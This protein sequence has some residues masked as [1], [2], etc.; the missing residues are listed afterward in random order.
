VSLADIAVV[1][2]LAISA[3]FAF[4]RGLV[5]EVLSVA[6][7]VGAGVATYFG[8]PL[9]RPFTRQYI[10]LAIVAD[11]V[12]GLAI[13]LVVLVICSIISHLL[14]RGVRA[15]ALGALDRS[16]GL[17]F[18]LARGAL[19]VCVL[20]LLIDWWFPADQRPV[21]VTEAK[22]LPAVAKGA[23][24]LKSLERFFPEEFGN[25]GSEV[26][27]SARKQVEQ[28]VELGKATGVLDGVGT[29]P[30]A[31]GPATP[32]PEQSGTESA[33]PPGDSGYKDADRKDLDKVFQS[34]GTQ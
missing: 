25:R 8:L 2:I 33:G 10:E 23:D 27:D 18:G 5:R 28:A 32:A 22:S 6:A 14:S 34:Q 30:A 3:L 19:L 11:V 12:T 16:L 21:W 15:S 31:S 9:L 4:W 26:V 24:M 13:F 7:W 20:F 17:L 29:A 1:A